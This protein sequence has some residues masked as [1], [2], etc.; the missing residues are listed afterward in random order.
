VLS[1]RIEDTG[2]GASDA[3]FANT[4]GEGVGLKNVEERLRGYYGEDASLTIE[5]RP[6]SGATVALRLPADADGRTR[7]RAETVATES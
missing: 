6:G 5:S 7:R 2:P 3:A 4:R 1:L